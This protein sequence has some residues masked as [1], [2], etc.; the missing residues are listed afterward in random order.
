[1]I[2]KDLYNALWKR[3]G[4][5]VIGTFNL[6]S[7]IETGNTRGYMGYNEIF[8]RLG[9]RFIELPFP[10]E[11]DAAKVINANGITEPML[12]SSIVNSSMGLNGGIDLRRVER[13]VHAEKTK[14][15][16]SRNK[17]F[18]GSGGLNYVDSNS[19]NTSYTR[20]GYRGYRISSRLDR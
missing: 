16:G 15:I 19:T 20:N 1:M 13:L 12:V 5:V 6:K 2:I 9:G 18:S 8:S 14:T 10:D 17:G 11:D 7:R 3:C 4:I